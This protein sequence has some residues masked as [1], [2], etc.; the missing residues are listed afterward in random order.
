[1]MRLNAKQDYD[2]VVPGFADWFDCGTVHQCE[3]AACSSFFKVKKE[4]DFKIYR[5]TMLNDYCSNPTTKLNVQDYVEKFGEEVKVIFKNLEAYELINCKTDVIKTNSRV[6]IKTSSGYR[7]VNAPNPKGSFEQKFME[8]L[9]THVTENVI[10]SQEDIKLAFVAIAN[11][12][13]EDCKMLK[14]F[15]FF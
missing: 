10:T 2:I 4:A 15:P 11:I 14:M 9:C 7:S 12:L 3:R 1:M 5:N 6:L 13:K 8:S